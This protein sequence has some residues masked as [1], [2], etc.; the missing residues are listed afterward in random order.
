MNRDARLLCPDC[1]Y[2]QRGMPMVH[3][4]PECGFEFDGTQVIFFAPPRRVGFVFPVIGG[5]LMLSPIIQAV[6]AGSSPA[7]LDPGWW[8]DAWSFWIGALVVLAA[9]GP[10]VLPRWKSAVIGLDTLLLIGPRRLVV[11]WQDVRSV[12]AWP[13]L[14]VVLRTSC[15]TIRVRGVFD[16][17]EAARKFSS[18]ARRR[19]RE[20]RD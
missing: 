17:W 9:V 20:R 2:N 5:L 15:G 6:Q 18:L 16:S 8:A 11:P 4:C 7:L 3:K 19:I 12:R 13:T 1:S 10:L 14:T